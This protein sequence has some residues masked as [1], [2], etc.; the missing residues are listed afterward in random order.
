M[1]DVRLG[2]CGLGS[3]VSGVFMFAG[4]VLGS[5]TTRVCDLLQT[6]FRALDSGLHLVRVPKVLAMLKSYDLR[7]I[8]WDLQVL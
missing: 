2:F 8:R 4:V 7:R 3:E 5:L 6:G 1:F